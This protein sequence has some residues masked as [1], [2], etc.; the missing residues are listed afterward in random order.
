MPAEND[1][2]PT[3]RSQAPE[4]AAPAAEAAPPAQDANYHREEAR[5]AYAKRDEARREAAAAREL[6]E[7]AT[8]EAAACQE[9]LAELVE[10]KLAAIPARHRRLVPENLPAADRLRYLIVHEELLAA[11]P[12]AAV[13][14]PEKPPGPRDGEPAFERMS[15]AELRELC[16]SDPGRYR[17]VA[18]DYLRR[19]SLRGSPRNTD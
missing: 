14:G 11:P 12:G 16:G 13:P 5:K 10:R 6:A 2:H 1:A 8:A 19:R 3:A 9:L 15:S 7:K 17:R 4:A 18:D